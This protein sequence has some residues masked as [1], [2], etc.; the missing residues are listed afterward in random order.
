MA[1]RRPSWST[2]PDASPTGSSDRSALS[3]SPTWCNG[4]DANGA[5]PCSLELW[6]AF[7][8]RTT[9]ELKGKVAAY[10]IWNEPDL[11]NNSTYG[12]GWDQ[13][14]YVYPRYVD[15]LIEASKIIRAN[16]PGVLVVGPVVSGKRSNRTIELFQQIENTWTA[17]GHNASEYLDVISG[18]MLVDDQTHSSDAALIY[19]SNVTN[20]IAFYNP[21][22][23]YK[24]MWIT[25]FGWHSNYSIS[26]DS[27]RV[28]SKNL[29][30]E[31]TGGAEHWLQGWNFTNA[32]LYVLQVC[33]N[34]GD[35][36]QRSIYRCPTYPKKIVTDYL[37][38]LG[39]PAVQQPYQPTE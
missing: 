39:W 31:M 13:A 25:E 2:G 33:D 12:V 14:T 11:I 32:F 3:G 24:P 36:S 37:I 10:E 18:H 9:T 19:R 22:N 16:D 5:K 4:G 34:G 27:Q 28:R 38:P 23:R 1:C 8:D 7:V 29:L 21:R 30:I 17:D 26:E 15:Y 20:N 35:G 6:K